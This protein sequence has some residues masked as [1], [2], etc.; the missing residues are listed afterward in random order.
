MKRTLA[1]LT[2]ALTG[3]AGVCAAP[4]KTAAAGVWEV[5]QLQDGEAPHQ[6]E[7]F[8]VFRADGH[9]GCAL[10]GRFDVA[11][12]YRAAGS[13]VSLQPK[14]ESGT[15]ALTVVKDGVMRGE[16]DSSVLEFRRRPLGRDVVE[17]QLPGQW[18]LVYDEPTV[19]R[20]SFHF[21]DDGSWELLPGSGVAPANGT[22][23]SYIVDDAGFIVLNDQDGREW[24]FTM[25]E[26][27]AQL[28]GFGVSANFRCQKKAASPSA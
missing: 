26:G 15:L 8:Y 27:G 28:R 16:K 20:M 24:V 1:I 22:S 23:G 14:D 17:K 3:A 12:T 21:A 4:E 19:D 10:P 7:F 6:R 5:W 11:G 25:E 9:F 2:L 18:E 13:E